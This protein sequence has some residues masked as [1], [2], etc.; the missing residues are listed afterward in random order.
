[1]GLLQV[2][3]RLLEVL[4]WEKEGSVMCRILLVPFFRIER[5]SIVSDC[6]F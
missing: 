6:L 3:P 5:V 1:M 4:E 2:F